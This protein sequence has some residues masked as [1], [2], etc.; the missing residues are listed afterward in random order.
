MS[1]TATAQTVLFNATIQEVVLK[2]NPKIVRTEREELSGSEPGSVSC[3]LQELAE[4]APEAN[5]LIRRAYGP[6]GA[7]SCR[8]DYEFGLDGHL[9]T[10]KM[11][12]GSGFQIGIRK[13]HRTGPGLEV[14][15]LLDQTG[16]ELERTLTRRDVGG[17]MLKSI[18]T[19]LTDGNEMELSASYDAQGQPIRSAAAGSILDA[20]QAGIAPA[21]IATKTRSAS[22]AP[23]AKRSNLSFPN[24]RDRTKLDAKN[25]STN[26]TAQ[27]AHSTEAAC[28]NTMRMMRCLVAPRA[29]RTPISA[30][31]CV[32]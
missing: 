24:N 27:P 22:D 23:Y 26:P 2:H 25:D 9:K 4:F 6:D 21:A 12:D 10:L 11:F 3:Y 8:E 28:R 17:R 29:M 14:G 19:D 1:L 31:L 18:S 16:R 13:M 32:T 30:L 5:T 20:R 15:I 7:L